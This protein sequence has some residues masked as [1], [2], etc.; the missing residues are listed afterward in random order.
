MY[1]NRSPTSCVMM[2]NVKCAVPPPPAPASWGYGRGRRKLPPTWAH[3]SYSGSKETTYRV[4]HAVI[5][6]NRINMRT[7]VKYDVYNYTLQ[8]STKTMHT[9]VSYLTLK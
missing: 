5:E 4:E 1:T 9:V 6:N 7:G 2:K 8:L 3:W